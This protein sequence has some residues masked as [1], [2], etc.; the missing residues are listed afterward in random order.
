MNDTKILH[1]AL[2]D[3][4]PGVP[5]R[6]RDGVIVKW[7]RPGARPDEAAILAEFNAAPAIERLKREAT[8]DI[9]AEADR[10]VEV[11]MPPRAREE[12]Q[13][14]GLELMDK[15]RPNWT[16]AEKTEWDAGMQG[17][18]DVKAIRAKEAALIAS[19]DAMTNAEVDA[20]D[21]ADAVAWPAPPD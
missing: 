1:R 6:L 20:L 8:T 14:R 19:L 9:M 15:G 4:H 5:F 21:M 13:A 3:K 12:L 11:A 16:A 7:G 2:K 17:W 18:A 10:R